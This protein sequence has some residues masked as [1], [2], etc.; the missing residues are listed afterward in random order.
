MP[1]DLIVELNVLYTCCCYSHKHFVSFHQVIT[2]VLHIGRLSNDSRDASIS[3]SPEITSLLE[4][5]LEGKC[6]FPTCNQL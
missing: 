6:S 5:A 3:L 2:A 1:T 4:E